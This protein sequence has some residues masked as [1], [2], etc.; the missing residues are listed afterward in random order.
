[1]GMVNKR[2]LDSELV[3]R[4]LAHSRQEAQDL[5]TSG[6]VKVAGVQASKAASQVLENVS[7]VVEATEERSWASRGAYKLLGAL[8][9]LAPQGFTVHNRRI[10]DA[11]ASHGGFTDV[12]LEHEAQEVLAVDV[13]YGQLAWRLR[14]DK[15]VKVFDRTNIRYCTAED[16]NGPVDV[17]VSDLSFISLSLVL[18][19]FSACVRTGGHILPMVKPQFE[20]GKSLVGKKGVV[21]DPQVRSDAVYAVVETAASLGLEFV[22]AIASP[23]PGPS[24]NVE[25]F[26]W[27]TKTD[28][29]HSLASGVKEAIDTA[30]AHGPQ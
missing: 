9:A 15:R 4:G 1:M 2:R 23:L 20:V 3:K 29:P 17:V 24:G 13:G 7:I 10:L 27:L 12:L 19:A 8:E 26:V 16:F 25:Y 30:V 14:T 28:K 5:I 18:P 6:C 22:T 11:G 21:K